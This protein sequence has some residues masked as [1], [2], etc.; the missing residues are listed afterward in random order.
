MHK[1]QIFSY[2]PPQKPTGQVTTITTN[3]V[4]IGHD[5][6]TMKLIIAVIFFSY[7]SY[8]VCRQP[9]IAPAQYTLCHYKLCTMLQ[10]LNELKIH[11]ASCLSYLHNSKWWSHN[12]C[13]Q[14]RRVSSPKIRQSKQV[15]ERVTKHEKTWMGVPNK[16]QR[17]LHNRKD[18]KEMGTLHSK[19]ML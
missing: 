13:G 8:H 10:T 19:K 9:A 3:M 15:Q 18:W 7:V 1:H 16:G 17:V 14:D 2:K 11:Y 6:A 5:H 12:A 4:K